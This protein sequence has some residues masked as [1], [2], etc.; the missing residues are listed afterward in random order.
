MYAVTSNV[1][2]SGLPHHAAHNSLGLLFFSVLQEISFSA[3]A[4]LVHYCAGLGLT[5]V[6]LMYCL[7]SG[8]G[9]V[10]K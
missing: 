2:I 1:E 10:L 5:W 6:A 4:M 7:E 3:T 8:E 9:G